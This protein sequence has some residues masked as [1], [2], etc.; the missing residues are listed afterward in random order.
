MT[1]AVIMIGLRPIRSLSQPKK[2]KLG[3][4]ISSAVATRK[5]DVAPSTFAIFSR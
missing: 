3:M 2:T 5:L 1:Q 4:M